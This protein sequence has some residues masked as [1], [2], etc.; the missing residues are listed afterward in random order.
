MPENDRAQ[1]GLTRAQLRAIPALAAARS[2][3]EACGRLGITS[4][5][6]RRWMAVPAFA[7]AMREA[8]NELCAS[9]LRQVQ[10]TAGEAAETLRELLTSESEQIRLQAARAV[11]DLGFKARS[12]IELE[13]RIRALE[14][15]QEGKDT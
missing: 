2:I 5:T 6:Y 13:E 14:E 4:T 12:T 1:D 8:Q 9:A 7:K 15:R 10:H 3:E 11:L